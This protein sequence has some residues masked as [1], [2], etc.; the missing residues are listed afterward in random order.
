MWAKLAE[1]FDLLYK[2]QQISPGGMGLGQLPF[3]ALIN[4][5]SECSESAS[6][7]GM[8]SVMASSGAGFD[9]NSS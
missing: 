5:V 8:S 7:T 3:A 9:S 6:S 2:T 4:N 1:N